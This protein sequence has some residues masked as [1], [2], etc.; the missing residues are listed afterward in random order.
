MHFLRRFVLPVNATEDKSV[1]ADCGAR[2]LDPKYSRWIS[3]DP[4]LAEYIPG[5]G[6]SNEADRLPGMGGIYNSVNGNLYHYAGNNP[7]RYVDPD[8]KRDL[9]YSEISFIEEILGN[10][11]KLANSNVDVVKIPKGKFY[12]RSASIPSL[13][14]VPLCYQKRIFL[15]YE[16][17]HTPL[18]SSKG[19]N[20]LIHESFHQVQYLLENNGCTFV[21]GPDAFQNLAFEQVLYSSGKI[22]VYS[23]GDY[24][25][26]DLSQYSKL[27][28]IPYYESQAQMVGDFAQL[29]SLAKKGFILSNEQNKALKES[30]RILSNSGFESEAIKWVKENID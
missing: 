26:T 13:P 2:Y 3:V 15:S 19:K 11:G 22:D 14:F 16:I 5:A 18:E 8:G 12:G 21:N 1:P 4:A 27:S 24:T 6:K 10:I 23:F 17:Y 30:A 20:T 7:V 28:D 29:Y 9:S 25:I